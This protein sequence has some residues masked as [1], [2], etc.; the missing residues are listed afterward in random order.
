MSADLHAR[1]RMLLDRDYASEISQAEQAWL[2]DHLR[3][4]E[5]CNCYAELTA[6]AIHALGSF[7]FAIDPGLAARTQAALARH[8]AE[9]ES[10]PRSV[11]FVCA[12]LP[13]LACSP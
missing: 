2:A 5:E 7:S 6:R 10:E 13:W 3:N 12:A 11:I 8:A 9:F 4:C 1:A